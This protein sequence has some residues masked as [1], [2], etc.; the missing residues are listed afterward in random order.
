MQKKKNIERKEVRIELGPKARQRR[1]K[2]TN[3]LSLW[4]NTQRTQ[5]P[6]RKTFFSISSRRLAESVECLINS[7][8][9]LVGKLWLAKVWATIVALRSLKGWDCWLT[10]SEIDECAE[11]DNTS[12]LVKVS[13][14]FSP[15]LLERW[16]RRVAQI[17]KET[18]RTPRFKELVEFVEAEDNI[19]NSPLNKMMEEQRDSGKS[20][21]KGGHCKASSHAVIEDEATESSKPQT[22]KC[23]CCS[24]PHALEDCRTFGSWVWKDGLLRKFRLRDNC[25]RR[26]RTRCRNGY[27]R[28]R[29]G[30]KH[31]PWK[32][33]AYATAVSHKFIPF[34]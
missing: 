32:F 19:A 2:C 13:K 26:G 9:L 20:F 6:S 33:S 15:K 28:L 14:R 25:L 23:W 1:Q 24:N 4:R 22:S 5:N 3:M 12:T 21:I 7:L 17:T 30:M 27:H 8:A 10:L 18:Q 29:H 11:M 16:K 31:T 34:R